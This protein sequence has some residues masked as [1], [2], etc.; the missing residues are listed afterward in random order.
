MDRAWDMRCRENRSMQRIADA[1]GISISTVHDMLTARA[2]EVADRLTSTVVGMKAVQTEQLDRVI[3]EAMDTWERS[4]RDAETVR[5][6][7]AGVL[8]APGESAGI[9][10]GVGDDGSDQG[11]AALRVIEE[12][13]E[14][15]GQVGDTRYLTVAMQALEAKRAIWGLDAPRADGPT[16]AVVVKV[17]KGVDLTEV[18]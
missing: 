5:T 14:A 15:K 8:A 1:L 9:I 3:E 18:V 10:G 17:Y 13:H 16:A 4:K 11:G 6:K 12:T 2:A 7:R